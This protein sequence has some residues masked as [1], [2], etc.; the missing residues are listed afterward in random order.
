MRPVIET[1]EPHKYRRC[2]GCYEA[3]SIELVLGHKDDN[4]KNGKTQSIVL[5]GDCVRQLTML[6]VEETT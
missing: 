2:A 3:P 6:L 5:C 1:R 4:G